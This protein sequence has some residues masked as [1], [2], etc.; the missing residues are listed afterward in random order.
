MSCVW[1]GVCGPKNGH[2]KDIMCLKGIGLGRSNSCLY[3]M[4]GGGRPITMRLWW[5]S[6]YSTKLPESQGK[7]RL[8]HVLINCIVSIP[9]VKW[10]GPVGEKQQYIRP[11]C[12]TWF[13]YGPA[14]CPLNRSH[15][16]NLFIRSQWITTSKAC[17]TNERMNERTNR[18]LTPGCGHHGRNWW[19]CV[20]EPVNFCIHIKTVSSRLVRSIEYLSTYL[21][22]HDP[23]TQLLLLSLQSYPPS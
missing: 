4:G 13:Q 20:W 5:W 11:P 19:S 8:D 18:R 6:R 21:L 7:K 10:H 16:P 9:A 15:H 14:A 12:S 22:T 2:H 3:K 17:E 23:S 1:L